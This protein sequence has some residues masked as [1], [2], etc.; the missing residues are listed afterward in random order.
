MPRNSSARKRVLMLV[1]D[2]TE[3]SEAFATHAALSCLGIHVDVA[4]PEKKAGDSVA[5]T[6]MSV[7][8]GAQS[9][10]FRDSTHRLR[11]TRDFAAAADA[12]AADYDGLVIPG[13]R[14]PEYLQLN[15]AVLA[16]ARTWPRASL[17]V[18]ARSRVRVA[19]CGLGTS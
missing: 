2:H 17:C 1:G 11:V 5:T 9:C 10:S 12:I 7:A 19:Q 3:D 15:P 6:I 4:S 18:S 14:A 16:L 13:G 8:G